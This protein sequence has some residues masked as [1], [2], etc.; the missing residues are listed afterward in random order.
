MPN[1]EQQHEMNKDQAEG[2]WSTGQLARYLG[3]PLRTVYAWRRHREGPPAL[4]VGRYLRFRK[5]E[6]EKR[7]ASRRSDVPSNLHTD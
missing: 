4:R 7:L 2:L 3:V 6:V 1:V 5:E